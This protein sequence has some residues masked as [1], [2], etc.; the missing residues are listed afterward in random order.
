MAREWV[1]MMVE[2]LFS[3]M[4]VGWMDGWMGTKKA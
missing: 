2:V 3:D 1:R 4:V